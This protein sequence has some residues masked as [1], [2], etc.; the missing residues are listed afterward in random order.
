M[1]TVQL[2]I[3]ER[4]LKE[5]DAAATSLKTTRSAFARQALRAALD[6]IKERELERRH[7][8]GYRRKP[9]K[10]KEFGLW[11]REQVWGDE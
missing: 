1:R 4:L 6:R 9:V 8:E 2:T 7:R 3:D 10:P 5:V 11:E